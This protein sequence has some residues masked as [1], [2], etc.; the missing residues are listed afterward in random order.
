MRILKPALIAACLL[1]T[2]ALAETA[3][4]VDDLIAKLKPVGA[5]SGLT[6]GIAPDRTKPNGGTPAAPSVDI[7]VE[8]ASNSAELS[9]DARKALAN[10]GTALSSPALAG[11]RFRV[12]GHTDTV[13][14]AE[15]NL[16]L[17]ARRAAA[18]VAFLSGSYK[19]SAT[20]LVPVGLGFT[21]PAV[22]TP[23]GVDEPRNRRVRVVN[24]GS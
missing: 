10:L 9:P 5:G 1:T 21:E 11:D 14:S 4:S 7:V 22:P 17:S 15:L 24:L 6:R 23:P 16:D 18:V 3:P 8:F 12:E 2:P 19:I 20:R 13:G